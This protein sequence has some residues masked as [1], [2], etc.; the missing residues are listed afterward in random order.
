ML[1]RPEKSE[2]EAEA[3]AKVRYYDAAE[4]DMEWMHPWIGFSAV[5]RAPQHPQLR[6]GRRPWKGPQG[7][8]GK[9]FD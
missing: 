9:N 1:T 6:G 2:A 8:S 7:S 4:L 5:F 3:K